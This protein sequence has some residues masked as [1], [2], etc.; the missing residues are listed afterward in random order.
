MLMFCVVFVAPI[1]PTEK[2]T[3]IFIDSPR[4]EKCNMLTEKCHKKCLSIL[5]LQLGRA[6]T[7]HASRSERPVNLPFMA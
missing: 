1:D 5:R 2:P 6:K 7:D 3:R 4:V